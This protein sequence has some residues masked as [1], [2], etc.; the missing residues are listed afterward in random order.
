VKSMKHHMRRV[1]AHQALTFEE[2]TTIL[3]Q[4]EACLNSQPLTPLSN[5]SDDVSNLNSWSFPHWNLFACYSRSRCP[6]HQI[7]SSD[8][9]A[10]SSTDG[11]VTLEDL[12]Q[13]LST[14]TSAAA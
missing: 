13:R 5:D 2:M 11:S 8:T 7:Q 1:T 4:I 3:T 14:S 9:Q 12:V 10:T 6:T